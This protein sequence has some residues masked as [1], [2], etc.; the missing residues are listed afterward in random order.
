MN[1][2]L[3]RMERKKWGGARRVYGWSFYSQGTK[4]DR[5]ASGDTFLVHALE[6]FG[7]KETA[8]SSKSAWEKGV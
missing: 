1:E 5:Q 2:W 7:D 3:G 4:E 8:K 6:W